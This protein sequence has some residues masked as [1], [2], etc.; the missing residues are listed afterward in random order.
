[1][2]KTFLLSHLKL[3]LCSGYYHTWGVLINLDCSKCG[4]TSRPV[5]ETEIQTSC[6]FKAM[7]CS[8]SGAMALS[9]FRWHH[10]F[11]GP[12]YFP[13]VCLFTNNCTHSDIWILIRK[14]LLHSSP[15]ERRSIY[16]L[17][18]KHEGRT[19]RISARGLD[20]TDRAQRTKNTKGR[21]SP[22]TA[23]SKLG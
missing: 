21:F 9:H 13:M 10:V 4:Q 17:L 14:N 18:T 11:V 16:I 6:N 2:T 23:P 5:I 3:G 8:R 19:G 20:S 15:A 22:R 1:M 12:L 7:L